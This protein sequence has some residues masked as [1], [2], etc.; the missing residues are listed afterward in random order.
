MAE[1]TT[2]LSVCMIVKDCAESLGDALSSIPK[3]YDEIVIADTGSS[4]NTKEVAESFGAKVYD[5]VDPDPIEVDGNVYLGD[6]AAARNFAFS[7]CSGTYVFW[8][9]SD[10]MIWSRV[11]G[12]GVTSFEKYWRKLCVDGDM[13]MVGMAYDYQH[14]LDGD[15]TMRHSRERFVRQGNWVWRSPIHE[16][17]CHSWER[18]KGASI[19]EDEARIVHISLGEEDADRKHKRNLAVAMRHLDR[20]GGQ[21]E[22][23]L[24]MHI[25]NSLLGLGRQE[26]AIEHLKK[27]L[28]GSS[29]QQER[30]II[31]LSIAE[32][33]RQLGRIDEQRRAIFDAVSIDP[34]TR[35]AYIELANLYLQMEDWSKCLHWADHAA[36]IEKTNTTYRHNPLFISSRAKELRVISLLNLKRPEEAFKA[37]QELL[38]EF[39]ENRVVAAHMALC[40]NLTRQEEAIKSFQNVESLILKERDGKKLKTLLASAPDAVA[41]DPR[42]S[43]PPT[44]VRPLK[45]RS[46]CFYCGEGFRPWGP[47]SIESGGIG[48]SETAVIRM[49]EELAAIG[50]HVEV[51]GF[52]PEEDEGQH[53]GVYWYPF[54]RMPSNVLYD[55]FI[56]WR[57]PGLQVAPP[58]A[59]F[60]AVWLHDVQF[61]EWWDPETIASYDRVIVLSKAHRRNVSFIPDEKI[62]ISRNGIDASFFSG[63]EDVEKIPGRMIYASCPSR[64]LVHIADA[65]EEIRSAH[66][67]ATI[68]VFYGFNEPFR[69]QM[70]RN[71]EFRR[72]YETCMEFFKKPGVNFH[73]MVSQRDLGRAFAAASVWAYPCHFPEISCITAMQAQV[74]G[75]VP[76]TTGFWAL[77]ETVVNGRIVGDAE[78]SIDEH[79]ELLDQWKSE[80]FSEL[81]YPTDQDVDE[82]REMFL[83][84]EVAREWNEMFE[85]CLRASA[86]TTAA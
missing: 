5:Y 14:N 52:P 70:A 64:G 61:K 9:D 38:K 22:P 19:P 54:W 66:P 79:P 31:Q 48:G 33:Y 23:R 75:A 80:L 45:Q 40:A 21:G 18:Y 20:Q 42:I 56:N 84:S 86:K 39:P 63:F 24:H 13:D 49:A 53:R 4:D 26:E 28:D 12:N 68:D 72:I 62:W 57:T 8:F 41:K 36:S 7:K 50:W 35:E 17:L 60:R 82:L 34:E 83:W 67:E 55:V 78:K 47:N 59:R 43:I 65:W 76:V 37:C 2:T 58:P 25:G 6:F 51:Y 29:W 32:C 74:A 30:Y 27:Y 16:V 44:I 10:D 73:G 77:S 46:I 85:S 1:K 15:C 11:D 69:Q 3:I 71:E 81:S